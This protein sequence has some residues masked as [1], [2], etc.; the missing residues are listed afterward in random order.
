MINFA[1][2]IDFSYLSPGI[3]PTWNVQEKPGC[4]TSGYGKDMMLF[5]PL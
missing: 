2:I 1:G 4:L 3:I 5:I